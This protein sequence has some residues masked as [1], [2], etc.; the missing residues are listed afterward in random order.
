[1]FAILFF[2]LVFVVCLFVLFVCLFVCLFVVWDVDLPVAASCSPLDQRQYC[3]VWWGPQQVVCLFVCLG[4]L[5]VWVDC[6]TWCACVVV[7]VVA[8]AVMWWL[9]LLSWLLFVVVV[10]DVSLVDY[11]LVGID[12][13]IVW[14]FV[15]CGLCCCVIVLFVCLCAAL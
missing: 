14:V 4:R 12:G 9:L 7:A 6:F 2:F 10:V 1:M 13:V 15:C 11:I 8:V 5:F 3:C